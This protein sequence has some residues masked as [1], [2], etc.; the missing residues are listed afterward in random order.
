[1]Y[2][3]N[4]FENITSSVFIEDIF[5]ILDI[6]FFLCNKYSYFYKKDNSFLICT[7]YSFLFL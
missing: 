2:V 4:I 6:I 5:L 1:M 3:V 7:S